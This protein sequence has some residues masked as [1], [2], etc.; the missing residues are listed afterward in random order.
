MN[1]KKPPFLD[2]AEPAH[3][4]SF[5]PYQVG[6]SRQGED[7]LRSRVNTFTLAQGPRLSLHAGVTPMCNAKAVKDV[8]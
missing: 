1:A 3:G 2:T 4:I 5:G 6:C 7:P 8:K